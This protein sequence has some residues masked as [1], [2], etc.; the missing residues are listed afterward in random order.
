[1]SRVAAG[2]AGPG[3]AYE[4]A[5][6][7][8]VGRLPGV[9]LDSFAATFNLVR[10]ANRVVGDLEATVHR[11]AG[12]SWA[13][14][15]VMFALW[16]EGPLEPRQIARLAAMSRAAVSSVCNTLERDGLVERSRDRADRRLVTVRLT[17]AGRERL[18][19][20]YV[21]QNAEEQRLLAAVPP[22]GLEAFTEVLRRIVDT[23]ARIPERRSFES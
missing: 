13:G 16:V 2:D 4:R 10:A 12:W 11:P 21:E 17:A 6:A 23:P 15:R 14:F 8:H 1:M 9:S 22:E 20:A 19:R 18:E 5:A 3:R 7:E